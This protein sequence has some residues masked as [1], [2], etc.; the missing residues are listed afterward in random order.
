MKKC[1][2]GS[3][4]NSLLCTLG[5]S[6]GGKKNERTFECFGKEE[7]VMVVFSFDVLM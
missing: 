3:R 2:D 1:G 4:P 6:L 7:V 5:I